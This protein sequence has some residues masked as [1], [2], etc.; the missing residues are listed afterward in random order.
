M[1]NVATFPPEFAVVKKSPSGSIK[2]RVELLIVAVVPF[3]M[4]VRLLPESTTIPLG[5]VKVT[6]DPDE[7]HLSLP[8]ATDTDPT[9]SGSANAL[10]MIARAV[11]NAR[12]PNAD[13]FMFF[14]CIIA[15]R[16]FIALPSAKRRLERRFF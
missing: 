4:L 2:L 12:N 16:L 10:G 11:A 14:S 8:P 3:E 7:S 13:F 6:D 5:V 15:L 1:L 9:M